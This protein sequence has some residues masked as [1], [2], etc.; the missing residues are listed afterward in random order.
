MENRE[1][2]KEQLAIALAFVPKLIAG[3]CVFVLFVGFLYGEQLL[4]AENVTTE[5]QDG[6]GAISW[7]ADDDVRRW[8]VYIGT[9]ASANDVYTSGE[10][11]RYTDS[12]DV[13][14]IPLGEY[15]LT[16]WSRDIFGN[17]TNTAHALSVVDSTGGGDGGGLTPEQ[18][19]ETIESF[20]QLTLIALAAGGVGLFGVGLMGGQQR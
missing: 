11:A 20:D 17:W 19:A 3:V 8:W 14:G 16:V 12:H 2:T 7:T 6:S 5:I 10:L 9:S 1:L 15:D 13:S 4:A 18:H